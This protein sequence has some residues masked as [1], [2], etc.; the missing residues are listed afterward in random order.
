MDVSLLSDPFSQVWLDRLNSAE[1]IRVSPTGFQN[2]ASYTVFSFRSSHPVS[3]P[4]LHK[5]K[6]EL[7]SRLSLFLEL[8]SSLSPMRGGNKTE[9][10]KPTLNK[11]P[12]RITRCIFSY[13]LTT[14]TIENSR[15]YRSTTTVNRH[16]SHTQGT[17]H[18]RP[19]SWSNA[20]PQER[21]RK[22][23]SATRIAVRRQR[24]KF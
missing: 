10:T 22:C 6:K 3:I 5:D 23:G 12:S 20:F 14:A 18:S 7:K 21:S 24:L 8:T 11:K 13:I 1:K 19:K 2:N 9:T 16:N 15:P 4:I 17:L